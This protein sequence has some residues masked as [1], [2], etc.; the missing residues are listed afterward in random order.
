MNL[1]LKHK[2][3][4]K[5]T[6]DLSCLEIYQY[7]NAFCFSEADIFNFFVFPLAATVE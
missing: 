7:Q 5:Y 2:E 1:Y 6:K 4:L 3:N